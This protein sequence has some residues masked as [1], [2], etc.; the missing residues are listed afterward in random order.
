MRTRIKKTYLLAS[1]LGA[2]IVTACDGGGGGLAGIGG[3]G[4]I[5]SGTVTSF[6]SVF[7]N[8]V[9]FETDSSTFEIEDASGSQQDLRIG[10]VVQV[11]GSINADGITG[12][13]TH[14]K[15]ADDL[16]GPVNVL[17]SSADVKTLTVLG[18]TV[19]I[20]RTNT[21]FEGAN[22][23]F[24]S[25]SN[26]N[27]IE[28]SGFY[29]EL[30]HLQASYVELKASSFNAASIFEIK[31]VISNLS[32]TDFVV[33]G[34]NI[35]AASA[36]LNDLPN[37]FQNDL[38]VEV[39]GT[40]NSGLNTIIATEVEAEDN[41]LIDDGSEVEIEGFITRFVS[42]SDFDISG[43]KVNAVNA[44]L[45]PS[46][47][48]LKEGVKVEVEGAIN[49]GVLIASEVEIRGGSAEVSARVNTK[50]TANNSFT[51]EVF[52]GA[53]LINVQLTSSTLTEDE[54]GGDD[55]LLL[56]ELNE[57][58]FVNVRGFES[59]ESTITATRVKRESEVKEVELQGVVTAQITDSNITVL[60]VVFPVS[61]STDYEGANEMTLDNH[62]EFEALTDNGQTVV[63]IK[64]KKADDGNAQG[65]AD[66]V[67]IED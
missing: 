10:M 21:A 28:V 1:A 23:S 65:V 53:S 7:V 58:D 34:V 26:N 18:K 36:N 8:G 32:G 40:Y 39:K 15:Y 63:S 60:G 47:L 30:G 42:I 59:G 25:V 11:A 37:G 13:A 14:I 48:V 44:E 52:S 24:A 57:G 41:S 2:L 55:I 62:A 12:N 29:D 3:S 46:T 56:S 50:N 19:V 27:V 33:Q 67:E 45:T 64:D 5:S 66:E 6:G 51:V 9:E 43:Y 38:L 22:F 20:S 54:V 61:D 17:S 35:N 16:Q 49:N 31:G 4:Y